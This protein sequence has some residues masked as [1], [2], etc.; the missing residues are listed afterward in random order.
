MRLKVPG[1]VFSA[2]ILFYLYNNGFVTWSGAYLS[3]YKLLTVV[4]HEVYLSKFIFIKLIHTNLHAV[5]YCIMLTGWIGLKIYK[6]KKVLQIIDNR[7]RKLK[8]LH[9]FLNLQIVVVFFV[10]N[11]VVLIVAFSKVNVFLARDWRIGS[12]NSPTRV[13][14]CKVV[15]GEELEFL[16]GGDRQRRRFRWRW[17]KG[18]NFDYWRCSRVGWCVKWKSKKSLDFCHVKTQ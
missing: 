2:G 1:R 12:R 4:I 6:M 14:W 8:A 7:V 18:W 16:F 3:S 13:I 11:N 10:H 9:I 15:R 17:R 5:F